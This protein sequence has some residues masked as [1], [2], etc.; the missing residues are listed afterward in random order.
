MLRRHK[1]TRRHTVVRLGD[2]LSK[3]ESPWLGHETAVGGG[4]P[5]VHRRPVLSGAPCPYRW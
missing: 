1:H 3:T 5:Y 2:R 4:E